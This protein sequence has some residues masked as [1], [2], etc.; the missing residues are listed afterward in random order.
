MYYKK[1]LIVTSHLTNDSKEY[2][3]WKITFYKYNSVSLLA[4]RKNN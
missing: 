4:N 3:D 2:S 1:V